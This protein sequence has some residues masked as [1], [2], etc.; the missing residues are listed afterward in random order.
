MSIL[1]PPVIISQTVI[2]FDHL[3]TGADVHNSDFGQYIGH[4][5]LEKVLFR[6]ELK[7]TKLNILQKPFNV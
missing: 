4:Q 6:E 1:Y 3:V 7:E 2:C 5:I